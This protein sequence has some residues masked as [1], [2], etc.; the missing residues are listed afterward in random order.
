MD[1]ILTD[2]QLALK[3]EYDDFF[4]E[5]M[6]NSPGI[7]PRGVAT[8]EEVK[9]GLNFH[10]SMM[11]K[12]GEREYT[13]MAWPKEYG[14]REAPIIDQLLYAE[15][16]AYHQSPGLDI[17]GAKMFAPTLILHATD[18]QKKRLLPPIAKGEVV[19]CQGWSEPNAGSDLASLTTAAVRD[20]DNYIINGQKI[21]TSGAQYADKMFLLARTDQNE[22]RG[23][24]LSV[25][26]VDMK[27]PGVEVR[28][29]EYMDGGHIYNE[30]YFTDVKVPVSDRIGHENEGWKM[31]RDTM[32]FER[33]GAGAYAGMKRTLTHLIAYLKTT[34][35]DGRTLME[36]P[37]NRRKVASLIADVE[38]GR[39]LSYK[40]AW[41]QDK[42]KLVFSP[43]AA[44]ESK[45]FSS[46]LEQ[47]I[48]NFATEIMGAYGQ[49]ESGPYAPMNGSMPSVYQYCM[50]NNIAAG[51][52]EIQRNII[53]WVGVGLPRFV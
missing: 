35:R 43:A 18:E 2:E 8:D 16:M 1:L 19:Y 42:G 44:S 41:L 40:I 6:K 3:K 25:F 27:A 7:P 38:A 9:K 26:D 15:S 50:G 37:I 52:S 4:S 49:L 14:G 28:P 51:S 11:L 45:L 17:F 22:K 5:E 13:I 24:G 32:N 47:R 33:S 21:W 23:K 29:I 30:V 48:A 36:N 53:A 31:T 12:C 34:K 39:S 20:G 46:E 10:R